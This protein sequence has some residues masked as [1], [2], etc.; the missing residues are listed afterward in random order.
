MNADTATPHMSP[1]VRTALVLLIGV[2]VGGCVGG[3]IAWGVTRN[4]YERQYFEDQI[5]CTAIGAEDS[6]IVDIPLDVLE[7]VNSI[8]L[9]VTTGTYPG[10]SSISLMQQV[11]PPLT[12]DLTETWWVSIPMSKTMVENTSEVSLQLVRSEEAVPN[13]TG[14]HIANPNVFQF[15]P[16]GPD[17]EPH[18]AQIRLELVGGELV[19]KSDVE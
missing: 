6:V 16:N 13:I 8:E 15:S 14:S 7:G 11:V 3:L 4:H 12:D 18:V 9:R 2:I 5:V 10:D 1:L 17:C 19:A